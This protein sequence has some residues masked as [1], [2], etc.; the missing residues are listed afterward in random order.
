MFINPYTRALEVSAELE[1][2][3]KWKLL[4]GKI[5]SQQSQSGY[6]PNFALLKKKYDNEKRKQAK[7]I[8]QDAKNNTPC[9]I[10]GKLLKDARGVAIH[11]SRNGC[12][13]NKTKQPSKFK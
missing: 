11:K 12:Y 2:H 8:E 4:V 5:I 10:C 13:G 1:N 9:D 3:P 7:H 6:F